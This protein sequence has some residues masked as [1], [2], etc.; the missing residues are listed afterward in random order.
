[1]TARPRAAGVALFAFVASVSGVAAADPSAQDSAAAQSL[2]DEA[3]KLTSGGKWG[4]ACPKLEESQ[5]LDPTPVTEFYLADCY[6]HVGRTAS[7]W[8]TFLD[9]AAIAHRTG[10]PKAADRERVAKER[11]AA[12][13]PKLPKL[14]IDVPPA[15]RAPGLVVKRD[16]ELVGE[17]QWG[18]P[19]A[20]DPGKH[21][22][23]VSASGK[24]SW[25]HEEDVQ[26]GGHVATLQVPALEDAPMPVAA[27]APS[28]AAS[29]PSADEGRTTDG[30]SGSGL[31]TAGF[32]AASAGALGL[33]AGGV[34]GVV[35]VSKNSEANRNDCGAPAGYGDSNTC[36][37]AGVS[38]RHD[39]VL[40]G[41]ASTVAFIAGGVVL[42]TGAGIWLLAPS[43]H[44]QAAPAVGAGS[45]GL[46][47][48][49][50]F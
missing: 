14:E 29:P 47:V 4:D 32:I 36:N 44:V 3:R 40:M 15:A 21:S 1:M 22:V 50:N 5:R 16:G 37:P 25:T 43:S 13:E 9:L 11:A 41:N 17:G 38:L 35:A 46:L 48:R 19:V 27:A 24:K 33:I 10:G 18:A 42:A 7:A 45:A 31:K 2:Y 30:G 28:A 23:E 34:L 8:S 49:G 12:L 6:E 20:V 39:A 26:P